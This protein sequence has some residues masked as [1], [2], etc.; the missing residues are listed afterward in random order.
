MRDNLIKTIDNLFSIDSEFE[1][2]N[3]IGKDLLMQAIEQIGW[4]T[5]PDDILEEYA[6]LCVNKDN[7]Q[8]ERSLR[9]YNYK[10]DQTKGMDL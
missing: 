2:T 3:Q 6:R 4:R 10:K 9:K 5:L 8:T 7:E 1:D